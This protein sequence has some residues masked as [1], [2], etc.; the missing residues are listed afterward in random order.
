MSVEIREIEKTIV[1]IVRDSVGDQLSTYGTC[2]NEKASVIRSRL[3]SLGENGVTPPFPD[4]PYASVDY[5]RITDDGYELTSRYFNENDDYVYSTHKLASFTIRFFGTSKDDVMSICNNMH[6]LWEVDEIRLRLPTEAP[7]GARLRN[8]TD[9]VFIASA[10]ED[11]YRE[12][13]SF[14]IIVAVIDE[15]IVPNMASIDQIIITPTPVD[16]VFM[17]NVAGE[18]LMEC[19]EVEATCIGLPTG[20]EQNK[21]TVENITI[22][23][24]TP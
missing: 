22:E 8:K 18:I 6:M 11:K 2:A 9:A 12:I 7:N 20:N 23:A 16:P 5:T 13:A 21:P 1:K 14:D 4:Y 3:F 15:V 24:P 10:M 17:L 19:G